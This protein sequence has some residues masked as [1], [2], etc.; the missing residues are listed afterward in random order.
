MLKISVRRFQFVFVL[1]AASAV[2]VSAQQPIL[3]SEGQRVRITTS[4]VKEAVGGVSRSTPDSL[5]ILSAS[6][7]GRTTVATRALEKLE[8]SAGKNAVAGAKK[9]AIWGGVIGGVAG[10]IFLIAPCDVPEGSTLDC[11]AS[12]KAGYATISLGTG[13]L[14]GIVIG[15]LVKAEKW[16]PVNL[17]PRVTLSRNRLGLAMNIPGLH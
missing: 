11:S 3:L 13:I 17:Q 8:V 2:S 6:G 12:T 7:E 9:G 15:A 10:L 4:T 14:Y 5:V 16:E 1:L